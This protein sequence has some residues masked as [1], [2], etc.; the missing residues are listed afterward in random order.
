MVLVKTKKTLFS[1]WLWT[2]I[3]YLTLRSMYITSEGSWVSFAF[4]WK[5]KSI[6][7]WY[8]FWLWP[9]LHKKWS[10]P[11]RISPVNVT[12]LKLRICSHLLELFVKCIFFTQPNG[13]IISEDLMV[14]ASLLAQCM[15]RLDD[16]MIPV[17]ER[18]LWNQQWR[19]HRFQI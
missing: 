2:G 17:Q 11:L 18:T 9:R 14:N 10:F 5:I 6:H 12:S 7:F 19:C 16:T 1:C 3:V 8:F 13:F 4:L 15:C